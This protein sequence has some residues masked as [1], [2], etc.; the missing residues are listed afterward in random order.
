MHNGFDLL[1]IFHDG[2]HAIKKYEHCRIF[3]SK[4]CVSPSLL[5]LVVSISLFAKGGID[6]MECFLDSIYNHDG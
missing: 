5:H 6:F 3:M 2:V 4:S 1:A